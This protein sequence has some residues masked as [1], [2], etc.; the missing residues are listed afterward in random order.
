MPSRLPMPSI[1]WPLSDRGLAPR[2]MDL[3]TLP[4]VTGAHPFARQAFLNDLDSLD[5]LAPEGCELERDL[6]QDSGDRQQIL[7]GT[8]GAWQA[9]LI[10]VHRVPEVQVLVTAETAVIADAVLA[11]IRGAAPPPTPT[12]AQSR[13]TLW[14]AGTGGSPVRHRRWVDAPHWSTIERNYPRDVREPLARLMAMGSGPDTGGRL[15][16]WYGEPGTGKTTAIRSLARH[17]GD[18]AEVHYVLDPEA[19]FGGPDYLMHVVG[20]EYS[21]WKVLV[22]EDAD[23]LIRSDAR[24]E[25]GASLGRLLNLTDGILGHGLRVLLLITTNEPMRALHPAVVRPGRCLA[26]VQFRPFAAAEAGEWLGAAV[27]AP[28][29]LAELY[30]ARGDLDPIVSGDHAPARPGSYL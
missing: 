13:L 2:L 6:V 18:W 20:T 10:L 9:H 16:L 28:V 24:K 14:T 19:F 23:E 8:D 1:V 26:D 27:D 25:A 29:T 21:T 3:A 11:E 4:F 22:V 7:R 12:E 5:G 30:R 17:W 15:L